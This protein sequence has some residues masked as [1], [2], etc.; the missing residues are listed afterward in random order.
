MKSINVIAKEY[1][2]STRT[3]RY[4]EELGILNSHR[5]D[6]GI[7]HF[8]KREE[9]KLKLVL[10]GKTYGFSLEEIKEM[11]LLF[12]HDRSGKKQLEKTIEFGQQKLREIDKK[13]EELLEIREAIVKTD[14]LFREKL[15]LLMEDEK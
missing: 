7:R 10:R 6:K 4:Y 13:M 14:R 15:Q 8:S 12:D 11:V 2:L 3:L 1:G 5:V 9:A